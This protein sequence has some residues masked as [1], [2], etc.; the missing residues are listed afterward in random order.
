MSTVKVK[1][2]EYF[3]DNHNEWANELQE[4]PSEVCVK[5]DEVE[6]TMYPVDYHIHRGKMTVL[7]DKDELRKLI[8][9]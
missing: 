6:L 1:V 2:V 4:L 3:I 7:L 9:G 5:G 8:N